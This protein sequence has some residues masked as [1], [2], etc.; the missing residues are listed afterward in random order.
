MAKMNTAHK[1]KMDEGLRQ[2]MKQ[3][4]NFS[5]RTSRALFFLGAFFLEF[6]TFFGGIFNMGFFSVLIWHIFEELIWTNYNVHFS[7]QFCS[8]FHS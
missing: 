8:M 7:F 1:K 5:T 4:D 3:F 6:Y 2:N